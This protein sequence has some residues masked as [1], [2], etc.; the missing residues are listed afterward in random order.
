MICSKF[1]DNYQCLDKTNHYH[2]C[3]FFNWDDSETLKKYFKSNEDCPNF[4]LDLKY[5]KKQ[6][7]YQY[8]K[9]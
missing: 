9:N 7:D 2:Y 1:C 4:N 5:A 3:Q 8:L 6:L